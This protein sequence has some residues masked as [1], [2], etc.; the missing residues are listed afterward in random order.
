MSALN[1]LLATGWPGAASSHPWTLQTHLIVAGI[2][3]A[4]SLLF[5]AW[6]DRRHRQPV[7]RSAPPHAP[8]DGPPRWPRNVVAFPSRRVAMRS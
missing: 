2:T 6:V 4:L 3:L 5:L 8:L 7:F 1:L